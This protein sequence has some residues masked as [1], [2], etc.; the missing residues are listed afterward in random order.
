M[1]SLARGKQPF[2]LA[3]GFIRPHLPFVVPRPYWDRYDP[4]TIPLATNAFLPRGA[5]EVAFGDRSLGGFYEL[6]DYMD[7]LHTPSPFEGS[8]TQPQQRELKH[9]YYASVSFIDAQV[10]RLLAELEGLGLADNTVVV[11][12]GDHG[13]KLGE[14][15]G[16][17]KQTNYEVD[18]RAPLMFRVPGAKENGTQSHALVEF[19]DIYPTLCECAGLPVPE[20]LDGVSLAPLLRGTANQVKTAAFSQFPRRHEGR[21]FMGYAVREERYRYI[22]WRDRATGRIAARELYDHETDPAENENIADVATNAGAV[23]MLSARLVKQ[24]NLTPARVDR[25]VRKEHP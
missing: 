7:Y 10:G 24:F 12:W 4:A 8:L 14:H 21:R 20:G 22:E 23:A 11:L 25:P 1:R 3:V 15:N 19:V 13:W 2:F 9:G 16:W 6:R 18:T 5:P 17:C